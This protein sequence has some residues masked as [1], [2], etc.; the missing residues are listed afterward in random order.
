MR[1]NFFQYKQLLSFCLLFCF[2][3]SCSIIDATSSTKPAVSEVNTGYSALA[4]F[5]ENQEQLKT[6][7]SVRSFL[8]RKQMS[9]E[10][11][12]LID[13]ISE[14]SAQALKEL[15]TQA[16]KQPTITIKQ[17]SDNSIGMSTFDSLRMSTAK[18]LMFDS[19]NFEKNLLL[20]QT[21]ILKLISH[22]AEE[23]RKKEHNRKRKVWLSDL[24]RRH[25]DY[26]TRVYERIA[27]T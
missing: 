20:S 24:S 16:S 4:L 25:E 7:R 12:K 19:R 27:L 10:S 23:L 26:Y 22:L 8:T 14:Y 6:L 13:S 17:F 21:Q 2:T 1:H 18:Q 5:L 9:S 3:A 15:K 11:E